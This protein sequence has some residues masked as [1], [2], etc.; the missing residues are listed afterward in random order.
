[1]GNTAN[2]V[3]TEDEVR[4]IASRSLDDATKLLAVLVT[5]HETPMEAFFVL[6]LAT[7]I[8]AKSLDMPRQILLKG[9]EA[10]FDG[11]QELGGSNVH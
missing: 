5:K 4:E 9:V 1:M 2:S 10:S 8:L 7:T 11:L 6:V 3:L